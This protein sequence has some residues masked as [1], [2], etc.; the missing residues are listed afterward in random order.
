[1]NEEILTNKKPTN[2]YPVNLFGGGA[3]EISIPSTPNYIN[4]A[5]EQFSNFTFTL[6]VFRNEDSGEFSMSEPKMI[7]KL[8]LAGWRYRSKALSLSSRELIL[9]TS[10]SLPSD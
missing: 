8:I 6:L 1:M 5:F 2:R 10:S 9:K 7:F 4:F 3:L